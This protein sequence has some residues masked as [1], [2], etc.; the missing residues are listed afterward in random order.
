[1]DLK[2]DERAKIY[3]FLWHN[4]PRAILLEFQIRSKISLV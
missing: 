1:M 2:G 3:T 4:L